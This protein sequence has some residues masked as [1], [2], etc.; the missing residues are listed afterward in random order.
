VADTESF[1]QFLASWALVHETADEG[2]KAAVERGAN[3]APGQMGEGPDAFVD[4]LSALIAERKERLKASLAAGEVEPAGS[5]A[6]VST[7]LDGLRFEVGE[8][9]G[10]IESLQASLDA[11][12]KRST[13]AD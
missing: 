10:R 6:D 3:Q 11:L 9:R 13:A 5:M 12:V 7:H 2:W 1:M 8:L 4:G